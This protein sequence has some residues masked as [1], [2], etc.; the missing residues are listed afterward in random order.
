MQALM[1]VKERSFTAA[2]PPRLLGSGRAVFTCRVDYQPPVPALRIA[3]RQFLIAVAMR[4][5]S[6][7]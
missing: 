2:S 7:T 6:E 1:G 3:Y 5:S 4:P